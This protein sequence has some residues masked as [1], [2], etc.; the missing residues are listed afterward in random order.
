MAASVGS[1]LLFALFA[2]GS[3][4][5][6]R[7]CKNTFTKFLYPGLF[8]GD[9][10]VFE[11]NPKP[12]FILLEDQRGKKSSEGDIALSLNVKEFSLLLVLKATAL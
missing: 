1:V 4:R 11:F 8:H 7:I 2:L 10:N 6:S 5:I 12:N 3:T 9:F